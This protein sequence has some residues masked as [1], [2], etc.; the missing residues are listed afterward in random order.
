MKIKLLILST[1]LI[2]TTN[3]I[4]ASDRDGEPATQLRRRATGQGR[5]PISEMTQA[6]IFNKDAD[7]CV[8]CCGCILIGAVWITAAAAHVASEYQKKTN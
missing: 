7:D 8:C 3:N 1:I 5:K 4:S 6:E 2:A